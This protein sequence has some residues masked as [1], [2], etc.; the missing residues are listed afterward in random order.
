MYVAG[1]DAFL[2]I[3]Q[4]H[5]LIKAADL[6]HLSQ[7]TVSYRLKTLEQEL[8]VTLIERSKGVQAITLTPFGENFVPIAERWSSLKREIEIMQTDGP[9][10]SLSVAGSNSLNTYVLP[11]LY[12]ALSQHAPRMRLH[13]RTQHSVE[14][15]DTIERREVDVAFVK[16]ER[17]AP[18]ILV[19]PFFIDE[20]VLLR[21]AT[22]DNSGIKPAH[23]AD[24]SSEHE[25]YM[26]WSPTYQLWHD[27]W[28]D[29]FSPTRIPVD[30]AGLIFSLMQDARQWSIVPKSV[31]TAFVKSGRFVI[32]ELLE[33]PPARTCYKLTH[34]H[35]KPT[36]NRS[37]DILNQYLKLLFP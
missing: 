29:P 32:Q 4:S 14:I 33:S 36:V 6:L 22:P 31:A 27:R 35:P 1:I 2:A 23:P 18:N 20:M 34:K 16:L 7:A 24:L 37:L 30:T 10:L 26:N 5:S 28:W 11:P 8:G 15:Y 19:D 25:I 21:V 12:R 3:L 13:F 9:Q 17:T